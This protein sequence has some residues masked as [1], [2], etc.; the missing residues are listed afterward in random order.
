MKRFICYLKPEE[1][2]G[3]WKKLIVI[4]ARIDYLLGLSYSHYAQHSCNLLNFLPVSRCLDVFRAREN[5]NA[6][7]DTGG[8]VTLDLLK[9]HV[10]F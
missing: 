3:R 9:Y 2:V 5:V 6:A 10:K 8:F 4:K 1:S 7:K